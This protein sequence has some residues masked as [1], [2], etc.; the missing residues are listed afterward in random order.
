LHFG[1]GVDHCENVSDIGKRIANS[2]PSV[3]LVRVD[4][5]LTTGPETMI[6]TV[7]RILT[8]DD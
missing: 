7:A 6:E 2:E 3:M 8:N 5:G 4:G 1:Y